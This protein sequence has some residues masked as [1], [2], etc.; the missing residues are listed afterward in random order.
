MEI[1][2]STKLKQLL[3]DYPFIVDYLA[4]KSP[5]YGNLKNPLMWQT[6]GNVASLAQ[7]ASIGRKNISSLLQDIATE[8]RQQTGKE[9]TVTGVDEKTDLSR[10]KQEILKEII[11][12]LHAG[13][14]MEGLKV[15]FQAL[16][17]N[18]SASEIAA[19]EQRLIEE[20][21]PH[22]E[23]QRLCDVHTEVFKSS[24]DAQ[25]E[26]QSPAGHPVDTFMRENRAAEAVLDKIDA[27]LARLVPSSSVSDLKAQQDEL[28]TMLTEIRPLEI[29]YQRK[30][31]QLFPLLEVHNVSGP[32]QVMWGL[33]DEIRQ[34]LKSALTFD[35][36]AENNVKRIGELV[37]IIRDMIYKEEHILYPMALETLNDAEWGRVKHGEDDIGYAWIQSVGDWQPKESVVV[38][39][40]STAGQINI[41]P[42]DTGAL[43]LDQINLLLS[44]LPLDITFVDE[45]DRVAYYSKGD[46]RIFPRSPA[47]IGREVQKCHPPAS[48]HK[49]TK[50]VE[51]FRQGKR[52]SAEF[53]IHH[54]GMYVYIRY[55]AMRNKAGNYRG[56][57]EVS[58]DIT[59]IQKISGEKR[60]AKEN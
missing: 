38:P 33:H 51:S 8:I 41:L 24:L 2:P 56:C 47:V 20:G 13:V 35:D 42:L 40:S 10:E 37:K 25:P 55:F 16:I 50:I 9:I 32:S 18:V 12:D 30:E 17:Q 23:V 7:V 11:H 1:G 28:A 27:V 19:M 34:R 36:D 59:A 58:Q 48:L 26:P 3:K 29:H 57:L 46:K 43:S 5:L 60:I 22:E 39:S 45:N 21:M 31:N 14:P 53:W 4:E 6:V 15:R 49:V 52:D 54:N 44:H